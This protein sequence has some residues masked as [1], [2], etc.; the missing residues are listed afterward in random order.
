MVNGKQLLITSTKDL[1]SYT[2]SKNCRKQRY[3]YLRS[4]I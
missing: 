2:K 4:G 3:S 1:Q